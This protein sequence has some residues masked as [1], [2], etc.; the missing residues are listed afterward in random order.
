MGN[1]MAEVIVILEKRFSEI[2]YYF[3]N[4]RC[5]HKRIMSLLLNIFNKIK[6]K[7]WTIESTI[8]TGKS[9]YIFRFY[10]YFEEFDSFIDFRFS[11]SL[12]EYKNKNS[13]D[14]TYIHTVI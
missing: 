14:N 5:Y 4:I 8:I 3:Q 9:P 2:I 1:S 12:Y 6:F 10:T 7:T 13:L 11:L